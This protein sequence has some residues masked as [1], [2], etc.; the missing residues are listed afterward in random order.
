MFYIAE[1]VHLV[2]DPSFQSVKQKRSLPEG[3]HLIATDEEFVPD[4]LPVR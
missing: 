2:L 3:Q 1:Y 4:K